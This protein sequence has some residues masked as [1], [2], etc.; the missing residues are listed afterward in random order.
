MKVKIIATS[1]NKTDKNDA[2]T[3]LRMYKA[4]YLPQSYLPE[5]KVR[6]ERNLCRNRNF[7]IRQRT[8][9]KN[10]IH[11]Q[12]YRLGIDFK[13]FKKNTLED[14]SNVSLPLKVLV[15]QLRSANAQIKVLDS[16]VQAAKCVVYF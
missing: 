1:V 3:L 9:I 15:E 11:D 2:Y 8:A 4:K 10:R 16:A 12:A 6:D 7:L 5:K 14:L 13:S